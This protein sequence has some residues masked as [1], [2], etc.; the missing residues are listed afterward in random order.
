MLALY[1][2]SYIKGSNNKP[3]EDAI[4]NNVMATDSDII[5]FP[6]VTVYFPF[7]CPLVFVCVYVFLF[8]LFPILS[9]PFL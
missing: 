6:M 9:F 5:Y 3:P 1:I 7:A 4:A 2:K 8:L